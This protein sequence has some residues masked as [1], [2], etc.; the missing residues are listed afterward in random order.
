MPG[1]LSSRELYGWL[2]VGDV[3]ETCVVFAL[4]NQIL[5]HKQNKINKKL[6]DILPEW[7]VNPK[8]LISYHNSIFSNFETRSRQKLVF[9]IQ[10]DPGFYADTDPGF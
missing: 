8:N 3:V 9:R 2:G 7:V 4:L 10:M 6:F 5:S 1:K